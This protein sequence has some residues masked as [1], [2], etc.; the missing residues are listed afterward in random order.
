M[1]SFQNR[2][3]FRRKP[4]VEGHAGDSAESDAKKAVRAAD[5]DPSKIG[6][7][8][9]LIRNP[10][11][12]NSTRARLFEQLA[13]APRYRNQRDNSQNPGSTCNLTSMGMAFEGLGMDLGDSTK[14]QGE[15]NLY[16]D[17]YSK[18]R[19]RI[20]ADD[21]ADF[22]REKGLD[23][24]HLATPDFGGPKEA[25]SWFK[26]KI[27]P[28]LQKGAQATLGIKSGS[29]RHVVRLQWVESKGLR[30]DDPYGKA[31]GNDGSFGYAEKNP[32]NRDTKGDQAGSGDN[33]F[34]D[35]ATVAEVCKHRYVQL[36]N[37]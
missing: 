26:K 15:E 23:T 25:E 31:V 6:N 29:F 21:R 1:P 2:N 24:E 10:L 4:S 27:L 9:S 19:S 3:R 5:S 8:R 12:S 14:V 18:Q 17:F 13:K 34:L 36:Y 7:A 28:R 30:I 22:A 33:A 16:T 11:V 37:Q 32:T 20:Q 35:W